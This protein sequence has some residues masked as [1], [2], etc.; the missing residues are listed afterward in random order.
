MAFA[1]RPFYVLGGGCLPVACARMYSAGSNPASAPASAPCSQ[2]PASREIAHIVNFQEIASVRRQN[3]SNSTLAKPRFI[4]GAIKNP[5]RRTDGAP[6]SCERARKMRRL[7]ANILYLAGVIGVGVG[8]NVR[9]DPRNNRQRCSR[10]LTV[11]LM[12]L[13][14]PTRA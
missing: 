6:K 5:H 9:P 3:V 10:R 8:F 7:S 4:A 11:A 13:S 2:L 14:A 1:T 12:P